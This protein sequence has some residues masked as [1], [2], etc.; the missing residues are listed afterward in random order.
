M[1]I[2]QKLLSKKIQQEH[3]TQTA[4]ILFFIEKMMSNNKFTIGNIENNILGC[5]RYVNSSNPQE[6]V[7]NDS[8]EVQ[9]FNSIMEFSHVLDLIE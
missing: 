8:T 1:L 6:S 2:K 7:G 5:Y 9:I 3:Y 4:V